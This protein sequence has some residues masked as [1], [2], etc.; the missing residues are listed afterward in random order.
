MRELARD[1]GLPG[2]F[3]AAGVAA[4]LK[5]SGRPDVGLLV[6]DAEQPV[7]AA[8]FTASGAAAAPV[9]LNRERCRLD[10]LR[11][12]LVNSGCANAATGRRGLEDAAKTQGAAAAAAGADAARGRARLDR[13]D[14]PVPGRAT[15]S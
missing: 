15:R 14:Q 6:C 5:P 3:R 11:A 1:S 9:L 12:V 10:A 2:G 4:G 13:R 8:R 7:S